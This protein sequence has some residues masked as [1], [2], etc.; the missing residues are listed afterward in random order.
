[1]RVDRA[2]VGRYA[3]AG[4]RWMQLVSRRRVAPGLR[5]SFGHDL[6]PGPGEPARGGTAKFQRLAQRFPNEPADFTLLYLGSSWLPRD[7]GPL[8]RVARKRRAPIVLNQ[9]GV[10][11]PAW[12]GAR[13][14]IVNEPL[15]RALEAADHV[16]YQSAFAKEGADLFLGPPRGTWEVLANAVD[17]DR[18]TPAITAATD[19]PVLLLGG[20]QTQAPDRVE[21]AL[22]TLAA[23]RAR[24]PDARLLISGLLGSDPAAVAHGLG[25]SEAVEIV[26]RYRQDD[27]PALMRRAH[28][29]LHTQPNDCCP[30][31]VLE[32]MASGVPVV[33]LRSGGTAE[34][35]GDV[36]GV[37]VPH[38]TSWVK[39]APPAPEAL[40]TA[41]TDVFDELDRYRK[42]ARARAVAD[43]ALGPWL[44]RH[45]ELFAE[46]VAGRR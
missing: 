18:F 46:L 26:G 10:G 23:V 16:L 41:V 21:L 34:L 8:L 36:A 5:V 39:V 1:M 13:T 6:I 25:V 27:A 43:Y 32:A 30:S 12:A 38:E 22:R 9:N 17:I 19:G 2:R 4:R 11:Y 15:R 33:Y 42:A 44:D 31:L 14:D 29:L 24:L 37:G 7:L 45:G 3:R 40:A 20:D 28:I 35:V